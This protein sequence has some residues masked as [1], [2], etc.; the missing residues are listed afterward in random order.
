VKTLAVTFS[1]QAVHQVST[2]KNNGVIRSSLNL[3]IGTIVSDGLTEVS[4]VK[5]NEF[6]VD[7]VAIDSMEIE[8]LSVDAPTIPFIKTSLLMK[9]DIFNR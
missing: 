1:G 9:T 6:F 8:K 5:T 3:T 4:W 2:V 7:A